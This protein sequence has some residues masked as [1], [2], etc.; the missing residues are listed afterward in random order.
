L[1]IEAPRV[2][3]VLLLAAIAAPALAVAVLSIREGSLERGV[4]SASVRAGLTIAATAAEGA[5][6]QTPAASPRIENAI[7]PEEARRSGINVARR[8]SETSPAAKA[9]ERNTPDSA[10]Q[11][12]SGDAASAGANASSTAHPSGNATAR[13]GGVGRGALSTDT[14][15][16]AASRERSDGSR[17]YREA[18][19]RAQSAVAIDRVPA[20]RRVLV[21]RYFSAIG[22]SESQ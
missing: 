1:P 11:K 15:P 7:T 12:E 9:S 3:R 13:A 18:W 8:P 5:P 22:P 17:S 4:S 6:A 14:E 2:A 16:T 21:R 10:A 19:S 20:D